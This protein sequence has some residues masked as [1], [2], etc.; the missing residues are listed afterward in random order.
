[1]SKTPGESNFDKPAL[2]RLKA[3]LRA[4]LAFVV[5]PNLLFYII[6]IFLFTNRALINIDYALLGALWL[7]LPRK[8]RVAGFASLFVLDGVGSTATMYN[9][10]PLAGL[11]ALTKA[12]IGLIITVIIGAALA[13]GIAVA[14]GLF[15]V[16]FL[17]DTRRRRMVALLMAVVVAIAVGMRAAASS[18]GTFVHELRDRVRSASVRTY[19]E[20]AASD[21]LRGA[22]AMRNVPGNVAVIVVESM[23]D[24][25]DAALHDVVWSPMQ[26]AAVQAKYAV[27]TGSVAFR[28]GTTSG[29][30]RELCGIFADYITLPLSAIP[31]CLPRVLAKQGFHTFAVHGYRSIYYNRAIWYPLLFDS[32]YFD[33]ELEKG[34][35]ARRCGTQFRGICDQDAIRLIGQLLH[36]NEKRLVYW[37]TLDAHT[38]V[39]MERRP[40]FAQAWSANRMDSNP[41]CRI[42]PEVC[43]QALFWR[44]MFTRIAELATDPALPPTRFLIVGD[45]APAFVRREPASVFVPGRVPF[46]ELVPRQAG[47]GR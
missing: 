13:V 26:S 24:V 29:E 12:P 2:P 3:A 23:G 47:T 6:G 43:L 4:L 18:T 32:I 34:V 35:G 17:R 28:G 31:K 45:H 40:E 8:V 36:S 19:P 21:S 41:R 42:A 20:A 16:R 9:I 11:V 38:P 44:D 15:A 39:D 46:I 25:R 5:F 7:W 33:G 22:A 30:L 10:N 1:M 27:R 14:T 37:M